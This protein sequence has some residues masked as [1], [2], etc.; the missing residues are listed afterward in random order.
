MSANCVR[1]TRQ[2][3]IAGGMATT[4]HM[5]RDHHT[6]MPPLAYIFINVL[7]LNVS[8]SSLSTTHAWWNRLRPR[9]TIVYLVVALA[10]LALSTVGHI[11][12]LSELGHTFGGFFWAIDTDGETVVV[13]PSQLMPVAVPISANSLTSTDSIIAV[14]EVKGYPAITQTF[15]HAHPGDPIT[16]TTQHNTRHSTFSKPAVT[17]T[18]DIWWQSYGLALVAGL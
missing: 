7:H 12:L 2:E 17:F 1:E 4:F 11:R 8:N 16:Y 13:S 5:V 18:L 9:L 10:L 14:N 6:T 15:A 3:H